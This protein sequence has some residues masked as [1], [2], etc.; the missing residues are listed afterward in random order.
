MWQD[1]GDVA[2]NGKGTLTVMTGNGVYCYG[3]NAATNLVINSTGKVQVYGDNDTY[4]A[5]GLHAKNIMINSEYIEV[6]PGDTQFASIAIST[7]GASYYGEEYGDIVINGGTVLAEG[8][9]VP[10]NNGTNEY[11]KSK[12]YG[13]YADKDIIINGCDLV[14]VNT[15]ATEADISMALNKA[16]TLNAEMLAGASTDSSDSNMVVYIPENNNTYKWFKT[17]Y[18]KPKATVVSPT[19]NNLKYNGKDQDLIIPGSSTDGVIVYSLDGENFS[20]EIPTGKEVKDYTIYY[21]VIGDFN[22]N[23]SDIGSVVAHFF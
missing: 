16:P 2:I 6:F 8:G 1:S 5:E 18:T 7:E 20:E 12:S 23:D 21:K 9:R 15:D 3:I 11:D 10:K 13:I 19:A 17:P 22:H 14:R 4:Y